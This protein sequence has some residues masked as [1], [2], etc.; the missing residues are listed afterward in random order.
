MKYLV[1]LCD[2]MADEKIEALGGR[3]P[4]EAANKPCMDYLC[5]RSLAGTVYNVPVGMVPESDTANLAVMSYDPKVYSKGRSPLEAMSIG[6]TMSETMTAIRCNVVTLSE[7]EG[8]DYTER[9]ILDHSADEISTEEADELIKAVEEALGGGDRHFY[10]GISYR[11]CLLWDNAPTPVDFARPHDHLG[12]VIGPCLTTNPEADGYPYY[13]LMRASYDVLNHHPINEARRAKGLRPANSIWLWSAGMKPALPSFHEK[14]GLKATVISAVDLIKG[15]AICAGMESVDVEGATGN[16]HTNYK[17]KAD[18]AIEAFRRGQDYVYIHV[19]GPD[20]CGHRGELE[21]KVACIEKIDQ[22]ILQPVYEYLL[23]TKDD[24]KILVLPD[25]PTPLSI[26]THTADKV[27][28]FLYNN[29]SEVEGPAVYSE[30]TAA[31]TGLQLAKGEELMELMTSKSSP[32]SLGAARGASVKP[33][34]STSFFYDWVELVGVALVTVLLL[35]TLGVRHSPV[36]G[37]SMY[38]TLIGK[39]TGSYDTLYTKSQG[40]DVLLISGLFYSPQN[41]DIVIVQMPTNTQEPLVKR[42]IA[43]EGQHIKIDF[44]DWKIW[45][46]GNLIEE[47][48]INYL[49]GVP[50]SHFSLPTTNGVWEGTVP[51]GLVFVLGDNRN[52]SQ[53]SRSLGY[54]DER[55][56]VGRVVTRLSPL[57][58]FGKVD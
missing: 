9:T 8:I 43:T 54:I 37:S 47:D 24:F 36:I 30:E 33:R 42:V 40:Y 3:S 22:E 11:H 2:G 13:E 25:H 16:F 20:E 4:M 31:A 10:T 44:N 52:N 48:Y 45:I 38:P 41:G 17:G 28:F 6:L 18:A 27:P 19:E 35:M 57:D 49:E 29:R 53:D 5:A 34:T 12:Q 26:R 58:R 56:L 51:E 39:P 1:L 55:W 46:D 23:R 15:I 21:N 50:M 32:K 14:W 7:E